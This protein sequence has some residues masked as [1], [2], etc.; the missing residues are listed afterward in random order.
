[1]FVAIL[2]IVSIE[3]V[4]NILYIVRYLTIVAK[5]QTHESFNSGKKGG[6]YL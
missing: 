3:I 2:E 1:M 6:P 4:M 5:K